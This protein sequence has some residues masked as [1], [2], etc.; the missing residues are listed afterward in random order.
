M[1]QQVALQAARPAITPTAASCASPPSAPTA[2]RA[3]AATAW[4]YPALSEVVEW[5]YLD[6]ADYGAS[7]ERLEGWR[8]NPTL[9]AV[10]VCLDDDV[11]GLTIARRYHQHLKAGRAAVVVCL[12]QRTRLAAFP[13]G[14]LRRG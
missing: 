14:A 7:P 3:T 4:L 9:A 10:Y 8:R 5:D 6:A 13:G 12:S 2:A 11:Q 1:G